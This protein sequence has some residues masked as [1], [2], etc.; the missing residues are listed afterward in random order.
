MLDLLIGMTTFLFWIGVVYMYFLLERITDNI[1]DVEDEVK[2]IQKKLE[3]IE[4]HATILQQKA[5]DK[6]T[7]LDL[8][9]FLKK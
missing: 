3:D 9:R 2:E 8:I 4:R 5:K 7:L 6:L 1:N